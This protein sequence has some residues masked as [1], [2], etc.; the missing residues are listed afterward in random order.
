MPPRKST[1]NEKKTV[2]K[3]EKVPEHSEKVDA[4]QEPKT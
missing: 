3:A 2:E 4:V 1:R